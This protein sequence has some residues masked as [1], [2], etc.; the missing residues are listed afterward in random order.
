[1]FP[2]LVPENAFPGRN[3]V[4]TSVLLRQRMQPASIPKQQTQR[5]VKVDANEILLGKAGT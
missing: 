4:E 3:E 5:A 2:R 1:M